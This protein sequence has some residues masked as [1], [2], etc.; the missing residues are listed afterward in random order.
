VT[1]LALVLWRQVATR[2]LVVEPPP[3][4]PEVA[5]LEPSDDPLVAS[6]RDLSRRVNLAE[7]FNRTLTRVVRV[8]IVGMAIWLVM[9]VALAG[10]WVAQN[11]QTGKNHEL[12]VQGNATAEQ[13]KA[14][15]DAATRDRVVNAHGA[16]VQD[17][18]AIQRSSMAGVDGL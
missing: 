9:G 3:V 6:L 2:W 14:A 18:V 17:N 5:Q 15:Q 1:V 4:P 16:C 8:L 11:E 12:A 7:A 10:L 13:V